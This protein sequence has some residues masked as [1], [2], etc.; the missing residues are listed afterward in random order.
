MCCIYNKRFQF[1]DDDG[2]IKDDFEI[3][4]ALFKTVSY[5]YL[6]LNFYSSSES[7]DK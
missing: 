6:Y 2:D 1:I 3:I 5:E 4:S 7:P